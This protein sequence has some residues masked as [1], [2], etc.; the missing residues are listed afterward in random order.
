MAS[1]ITLRTTGV[2]PVGY[3]STL[4]PGVAWLAV[5]VLLLGTVAAVTVYLYSSVLTLAGFIVAGGLYCLAR[6]DRGA[7]RDAA[8]MRLNRSI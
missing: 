5:I 2:S 8:A 1:T 6:P 4:L 7:R 3:L